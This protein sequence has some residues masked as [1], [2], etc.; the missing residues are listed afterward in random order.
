ML[1]VNINANIDKAPCIAIF[2]NAGSYIPFSLDSEMPKVHENIANIRN[3]T[4]SALQPNT[5]TRRAALDVRRDDDYVRVLQVR[6]NDRIARR[7]VV[8][9]T[10]ALQLVP[11]H[12]RTA[13]VP[14]AS[15]G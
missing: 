13:Y 15:S 8:A 7:I 12:T 4:M 9:H 3:F 5:P 10:Y 1:N 6:L 14:S 11:Q 2:I